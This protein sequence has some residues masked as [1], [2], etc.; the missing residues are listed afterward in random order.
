MVQGYDYYLRFIARFPRVEVLAAASQDEVMNAWQG[1][2]YYSRA[3]NLHAAAKS[4]V[5]QGG[6]PKTYEGVRALKGVGDYTAAAICSFAYGLPYA[7]VDGNVY[8]VL[9]RYYG[10][11]EPI[12]TVKGKRL[13]AQLA[14]EALDKTRPG[15]YNQALMDFGALQCT[16]GNP[17]CDTC[18]LQ[19]SCMAFAEKRVGALPVKSKRTVVSRRYFVYV[20]ASDGEYTYIRCRQS[21]DIWEGLY[22]PLLFEFPAA[23]PDDEVAAR[24]EEAYGSAIHSVECLKRNVK[25]VLTH[26]HIYVDFYYV[27]LSAPVEIEG[28]LR[29]NLSDLG[30]YPVSSLVKS[31]FEG[32]FSSR[33]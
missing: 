8:R 14:Q 29:I 28:Y 17:A 25:H 15:L 33:P 16:P 1:L 10:I 7:A 9:S 20:F 32:I 3:R 22:E 6:F 2:G 18:P 5:E 30:K 26:R 12:D 13:F 24:I 31:L 11:D 19:C 23:A 27:R 4:I 21:G